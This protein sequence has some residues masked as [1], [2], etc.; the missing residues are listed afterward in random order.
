MRIQIRA[1]LAKARAANLTLASN[2]L[3][4]NIMLLAK[5][6]EQRRHFI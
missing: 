5:Y 2:C 1:T 3:I 4:N 6:A